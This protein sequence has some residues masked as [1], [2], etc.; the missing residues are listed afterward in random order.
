MKKLEE[1]LK[2]R[3]W[4]DREINKATRILEKAKKQE[5]RFLV[6]PKEVMI[7]LILAIAV[8][9]NI[10]VSMFLVPVLMVLESSLLFTILI[11]V[12]ALT[13]GIIFVALIEQIENLEREYHMLFAIIVP[14]VALINFYLIVA[15]SNRTL[16][17]LQVNKL[18]QD[19]MVIS[20]VYTVVF[21]LPYL[22]SLR[23][24]D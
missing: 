12:I 10:C 23:N 3:G 16:M 19:P 15:Y 13:M 17:Q 6:V 8:A 11:V 7:F 22:F 4:S 20:I 24:L 1:R 18:F 9:G 14:I 5:S 21:L 2:N